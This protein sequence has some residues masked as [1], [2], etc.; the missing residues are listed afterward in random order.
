MYEVCSSLSTPETL[1]CFLEQIR[2]TAVANSQSPTWTVLML[3]GI[4]LL[5]SSPH[6]FTFS[7]TD[8]I[9]H[10]PFLTNLSST[11]SLCSQKMTYITEK[12]TN[13][14]PSSFSVYT[15]ASY[16][17]S[18]STGDDSFLFNK[19][20]FNY[21]W[22]Y[23]PTAQ[24]SHTIYHSAFFWIFNILVL[25]FTSRIQFFFKITQFIIIRPQSQ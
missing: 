2:Y 12:E 1:K 20:N 18:C 15:H 25:S 16:L 21:I 4:L 17:L 7:E 22:I 19:A 11:P 10:S 24:E 14:L 5:P 23:S 6:S 13:R 3:L 8:F 9:T